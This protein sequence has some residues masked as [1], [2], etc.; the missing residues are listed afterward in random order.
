[1]EKLL[2][3]ATAQADEAEVFFTEDSSDS[4]EFSDS[5][6]DKA[7]T[8]MSAGIALRVIKDGKIGLA[9]TR[10][11]LDPEALVKQALQSASNGMEVA[12]HFP[13][14]PTVPG[15]ETFSP[16]V[17]KL[18]KEELIGRGNALIDYVNART[19]GQFNLNYWYSLAQT[20]IMNS[21][22]TK[23]SMKSTDFAVFGQL[24]FPGTGSGLYKYQLG[25]KPLDI[26]HHEVDE[27]IELYKICETEVVP[28]T[29]A[30]PVIFTEQTLFALL[31]RFFTAAH[32]SYFYSKVSPLLDKFGE[33]IVSEKLSLWQDPYDPEMAHTSAFDGEGMPTKKYS[34]IENGI[35]QAIPLDLN[36]AAKLNMQPSGN[37]MRHSV[38]NQ[39]G[40]GPMN[41]CMQKGNTSLKDMISG[42]DEGVIVYSLMGAH[43]GNILAGEYSVGVSSGLYI[44]NGKAVGR[45]KDCLISGN[46]YD[47][48]SHIAA[49]E[50]V[51]HNLGSH[52]LSAILCD[53]VSVAGK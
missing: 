22:G 23:L 27:M 32:P 31:S 24:I 1:M 37:G 42:I 48:L 19:Q 6:L 3:L 12:F 40:A 26:S 41:I 28:P 17:E 7:D 30:M 44:K 50:N 2:A 51:S 46:A 20:G 4:I 47:T 29:K 5:K 18:Q 16:E 15:L 36:Y 13:H 53:N 21:A 11:L 39:P 52:K 10:N 38:E 9:H 33:K 34:F 45:V 49:I 35:F 14:T 25:R 8:S 43:S